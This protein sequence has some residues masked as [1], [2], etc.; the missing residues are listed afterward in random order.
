MVV[1]RIEGQ[2]ILQADWDTSAWLDDLPCTE[3]GTLLQE[4]RRLVVVSPH[5]DDEVLGCAGIMQAAVANDIAVC[6]VSVT[7]GEACYPDQPL[8]PAA[9]LRDARR[10]ELAHAMRALG[11]DA[12]HVLPLGLPDGR[13]ASHE[14]ELAAQLAAQSL[15]GDLL[16]APW[17]RDAHPDH[18]A[19]G[20]AAQAA[21]RGRGVRALQ[22]PVW[23]WHW[24]DP[25]AATAPWPAAARIPMGP[26]ALARKHQAMQAFAT[27]TGAVDGLD[28]DPILPDHVT[29]RFRRP[30]EVLI[31]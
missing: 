25:H 1:P 17:V 30:Y 23:A 22:Y 13:V 16:V 2:G 6:V 3:A 10:R 8:W 18:E 24:L 7:D 28:C 11:L 27:Q 21:A 9:R 20:R 19:A 12:T 29:A 4:V 5:P 31:G 15:P 26:A 14:A